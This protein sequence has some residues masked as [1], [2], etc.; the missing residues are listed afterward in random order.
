MMARLSDASLSLAQPGVR[1]PT[2]DRTAVT[3]GIVHLGVG[4]FHRA[5]QAVY[6]DDCLG[7]GE[8][9]WGIVGV[10]LRSPAARDALGPQDGLYTHLERS[11]ARETARVV[12]A[13]RD[14]LVAPEDPEQVLMR[15][16]APDTRIVTLTITEK[17]YCFDPATGRLRE[18]LPEI[19]ADIANPRR[20]QTA[21]GYIL[22]VLHGRRAAGVPPYTVLSCDNLFGNGKVLRQVVLDLA[23]LT[24]P[25]LAHFV[26]GEVAFPSTMVDRIVPA[27]TNSDQERAQAATG[28]EDAHPV[29]SETFAQWVIEDHF[30]AGRPALESV[31]AQLVTD[32]GPF[33]LM[34]LRL[35]NGTH[36]L[37]AYCGLLSGLEAIPEVVAN[38][39]FAEAA[40]RYMAE[41][42]STVP[43][44]TGTDLAA[45]ERSVLERFGNASIRYGTA[46]VA[47]DSSLKLAQRVV[48]AAV[49]RLNADQPVEWLSLLVAAWARCVSGQ[50]GRWPQPRDPQAENFARIA[51]HVGPNAERLAQGY[52]SIES[53]FGST[54]P[55]DQRFTNAVTQYLDRI[56]RL[57]IE[58]VL[59]EKLADRHPRT[60]GS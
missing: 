45:Y 44:P 40:R 12:G 48:P 23:R 59:S 32:V 4:A 50:E 43:P 6:I 42:R 51:R 28:L 35:V 55:K 21:P 8:T 60:E 39:L 41:V 16:A 31:G 1:R 30:T 17:G 3:P 14:V 47:S 22:A 18:A 15:L 58:G 52:L 38:P 5:H 34:K 13:L 25:D 37:L 53:I 49:D 24:D 29:V 46:Q 2:Y 7:A 26:E 56:M 57:G 54:L 27:T 9:N 11:D 36:S 33:E 10:S 19:R 20:P